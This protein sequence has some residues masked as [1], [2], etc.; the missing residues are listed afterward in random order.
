V[1]V[2]ADFQLGTRTKRAQPDDEEK[3]IIFKTKRS[4]AWQV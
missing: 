3:L 2:L 1:L 4:I